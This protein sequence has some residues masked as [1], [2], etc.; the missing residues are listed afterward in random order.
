MNV[1]RP[2]IRGARVLDLYAG[3]GALGLEALSRGAAHAT[4]VER[5]ARVLRFLR[6]NIAALDVADRVT[7]VAGDALA[8][9][10]RLDE[11]AFDIALA[12]P[13]YGQ[14]LAT[15]LLQSY[16]RRPFARILSVEHRADEPLALPPAAEERR[17]GDTLI[18]F[19]TA[20]DLEEE[21]R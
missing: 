7:V 10:E 1:L 17:Y 4:F 20:A 16:R 21:E 14:G 6:E 2:V 3:S 19:V 5:D 18:A 9:V 8:Y 13:P 11:G 15:R 12:D